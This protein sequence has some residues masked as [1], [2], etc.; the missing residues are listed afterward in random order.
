VPFAS[1]YV[2]SG[3]LRPRGVASAAALLLVSFALAWI[4][5]FVLTATAG[6]LTLVAI[7]VGLSAGV[8]A[9]DRASRRPETHPRSR[10]A[11]PV[12]HPA[13]GSG[14]MIAVRVGEEPSGDR[15]HAHRLEVE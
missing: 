15:P 9:V 11:N 7:M 10:R 6:Y 1:G 2:P 14:E 4:E 5:R 3:E 12:S 13:I 8:M